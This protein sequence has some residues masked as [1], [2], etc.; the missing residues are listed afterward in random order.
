MICR[1]I[2]TN[3]TQARSVRL[4]Q[5]VVFVTQFGVAGAKDRTACHSLRCKNVYR[6][7]QDFKSLTS[8]VPVSA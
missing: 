5:R 8:S 6:L 2:P 4:T 1:T 3:K 7:L